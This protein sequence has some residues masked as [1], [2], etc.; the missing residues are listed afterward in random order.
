M[1][2]CQLA[3]ADSLCGICNGL[4][5]SR[6][7]LVHVGL[8]KAPSRSTLSRANSHSPAALFEDVFQTMPARFFHFRNNRISLQEQA[9]FAGMWHGKGACAAGPRP[10]RRFA[11]RKLDLSRGLLLTSSSSSPAARR[12]RSS[13]LSETARL[14]KPQYPARPDHP[15]DRRGRPQ[16]LPPPVAR[17]RCLG[18]RKATRNRPAHQLH[19]FRLPHHRQGRA[20]PGTAVFRSAS[21]LPSTPTNPVHNVRGYQ[22][23]GPACSRFPQHRRPASSCG[24]PPR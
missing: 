16:T 20:H 19:G 9:A 23:A 21:R 17:R 1:L 5:C 15:A 24:S 8:D 7:R 13:K 3:R 22:C 6:G 12:I 10:A 18:R 14:L 11:V 2:F 4:A